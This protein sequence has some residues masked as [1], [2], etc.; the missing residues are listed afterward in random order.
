MCFS[1]GSVLI[2]LNGT[3]CK[4]ILLKIVKNIEQIIYLPFVYFMAV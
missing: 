4:L 1:F 3:Y 2:T